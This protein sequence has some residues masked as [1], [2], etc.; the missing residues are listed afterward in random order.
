[1][2]NNGAS[3]QISPEVGGSFPFVEEEIE[4]LYSLGDEV[5]VHVISLLLCYYILNRCVPAIHLG[6]LVQRLEDFLPGIPA[7]SL[8]FYICGPCFAFLPR[9][10]FTAIDR[11][12]CMQMPFNQTFE[13]TVN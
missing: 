2:R 5:R 9:Q 13:I 11:I 7:R 8:I 1:M 10:E 12:K 6:M 4:V 3:A